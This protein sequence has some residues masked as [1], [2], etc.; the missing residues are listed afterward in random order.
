MTN[1]G[2]PIIEG[3]KSLIRLLVGGAKFCGES[4]FNDSLVLRAK[5]KRIQSV[6][7][8]SA[9]SGPPTRSQ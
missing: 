6:C 1:G 9:G 8:V 2:F 3:A 4:D 7:E 5:S